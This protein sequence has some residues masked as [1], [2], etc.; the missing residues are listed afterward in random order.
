VAFLVTR[1]MQGILNTGIVALLELEGTEQTHVPKVVVYLLAAQE[2]VAH[3]I[4]MAE[5]QAK[6]HH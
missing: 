4:L 1:N 2:A 5:L 3:V 6:A